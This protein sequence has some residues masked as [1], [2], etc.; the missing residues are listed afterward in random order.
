VPST[1]R[2]GAPCARISG[3]SSP[4]ARSDGAGGPRPR[5]RVRPRGPRGGDGAGDPDPGRHPRGAARSPPRRLRGRAGRAQPVPGRPRSG[6][7]LKEARVGVVAFHVLADDWSGPS[8]LAFAPPRS[9]SL[10]APSRLP[11]NVFPA[12]SSRCSRCPTACA[13]CST[14]G[15]R[16][17][18]TSRARPARRWGSPP[19]GPSGR[20]SRRP[21][22]ASTVTRGSPLRGTGCSW[23]PR[24]SAPG[25]RPC[26]NQPRANQPRA[27]QPRANQ[28]RANQPRANQPCASRG[29]ELWPRNN[30][31]AP[32]FPLDKFRERL[33][34]RVFRLRR[35]GLWWPARR[36]GQRNRL[37]GF[38][39]VTPR[40]RAGHARS[41]AAPRPLPIL[42]V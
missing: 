38:S 25:V 24:A 12:A 18:P 19:A 31:E 6:R 22:S 5:G 36:L 30:R 28:P 42:W 39:N 35:I 13:S 40:P 8:F 27:N 23:H 1:S 34:L 21:R 11:Q 10:R 3:P 26:A 2:P 20:R 32:H 33:R 9:R 29:W 7:G 41:A 15:S 37:W 4:G 17:P 16:W 14:W